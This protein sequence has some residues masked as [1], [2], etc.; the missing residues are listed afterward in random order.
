MDNQFSFCTLNVDG[1]SRDNLLNQ[2]DL[3]NTLS[4]FHVISLNE[5]G[6]NVV[7]LAQEL[8]K[9]YQSFHI[10]STTRNGKGSGVSVLVRHSLAQHTSLWKLEPDVPCIWIKITPE[11]TGLSRD[12]FV[13]SIY[14]PPDG[15]DQYRQ[16]ISHNS[17][18]QLLVQHAA[19]ASS[20][21]HVLI[22]GDFNARVG[23]LND[24]PPLAPWHITPTQRQ[25]IDPVI[26]TAGHLLVEV[27]MA[28]KLALLTG[29]VVGDTPPPISF[30][31]KYRG[32]SR[33]DHVIA[34][35]DLF[36]HITSHSV[37]NKD[38]DSDHYALGTY[39]D[40]IPTAVPNTVVS[41]HP[42]PD[43]YKW[44][45]HLQQAYSTAIMHAHSDGKISDSVDCL[46]TD[47]DAAMEQFVDTI[48]DCARHAGVHPHNPS[49][50]STKPKQYHRPK[51][52]PWF[53]ASCKQALQNLKAAHNNNSHADPEK[54]RQ[55]RKK[56][57][58][59]CR[60]KKRQ[61]KRKV[62]FQQ[63]TNM[64]TNRKQ[65]WK[66]LFPKKS[67]PQ[68][69][70]AD[71]SGCVPHFKAAFNPPQPTT[72]PDQHSEGDV[73]RVDVGNP[74]DN[75]DHALNSEITE[76]EVTT[77]I[78]TLK[79]NKATG[80]DGIS[81]EFLKYAFPKV[82][83][84]NTAS[85]S[86]MPQPTTPTSQPHIANSNPLIAPIT[87]I[88]N[89]ILSSGTTPSA[90][91]HTFI[92]L[93]FKKGD[94]TQWSNYRPIAVT[95]IFSKLYATVLHNRLTNW[96]EANNIR[97]AA[98]TGFRPK[99]GTTHHA[100]VL[101]HLI[102]TH[103]HDKKKLY[104]CFIDLA[105]AYDSVP[106]H[107]LW[108]KLYDLDIK[109]HILHSIIALYKK[110]DISIKYGDGLLDSFEASIG[111]K[112]GC[113]L[114][115]LL[116]GLFIEG[117]EDH[118][119]D[120][121]PD[122][123]PTIGTYTKIKVPNLMFADDTALIGIDHAQLQSL[124]DVAS[125][126]CDENDMTINVGKTEIVIFRKGHRA[127]SNL[128]WTLNNNPIEVVEFF[129]YLGVVFHSWKNANF[130]AH[131]TT[132]CGKIALA[133]MFR[134]LQNLDIGANINLRIHMYLVSVSPV[135]LYGS[136]V[137][138]LYDTD[139]SNPVNSNKSLAESLQITFLKSTLQVRHNTPAWIVY[140]ECGLLPMQ[141]AIIQRQLKFFNAVLQLPDTEYVKAALLESAEL[142]YRNPGN[143]YGKLHKV[144][145]TCSGTPSPF[146]PV[147]GCCV[148]L[149]MQAW[150][151]HYYSRIWGNLHHDPASAPPDGVRLCTY[152]NYFA[153]SIPELD[154]KWE[155][156]TYLQNPNIPH[157]H[158]ISMA[159]FRTGS[160][161]LK[162]ETLRKHKVPR[163]QRTCNL[164]KTQS[165]QDELHVVYDCTQ[166]N[167]HRQ[168]YPR[169]PF[170]NMPSIKDLYNDTNITALVASYTH[171]LMSA[172]NACEPKS[173]NNRRRRRKGNRP[174]QQRRTNQQLE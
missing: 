1:L 141:H 27:C 135:V 67:T 2:D 149:N 97:R 15:S 158:C 22:Q 100:F 164:C 24:L 156:A 37:I 154:Q 55:L 43:S 106:R 113:P 38:L 140:R 73:N 145:Q 123:G 29:R 84:H 72:P 169:I 99:R 153:V 165:V 132:K 91:S 105:K 64:R 51:H 136:E 61:Y 129:K 126:W 90:W 92:T 122:A 9:D 62:A 119:R 81:A 147:D 35:Y 150:R 146:N 60:Q 94:P 174:K 17:R 49:R 173:G 142:S 120:R 137:W 96:C 170:S 124:I 111:V 108:K 66:D 160:H 162:I 32:T 163:E 98:Q 114:S 50:P 20:L 103:R 172:V 13:G 68:N 5:T 28:N 12:L 65:F 34:S 16:N 171:T 71:P 155:M 144:M 110:V 78:N 6:N 14:I 57:H 116:F 131:H 148:S 31:S 167:M 168:K 104:V 161:R 139:L 18:Y 101:N 95:P 88:F 102:E 36:P 87:S 157:Q 82:Q 3:H 117:L 83:V 138:G 58:N 26:N 89:Q 112:Q 48:K 11:G 85:P 75:P 52:K 143:W 118:I 41:T 93:L 47:L 59:T 133:G 45:P 128:I 134:K 121:L 46:D 42:L 30:I 69:P 151:C 74:G 127:P 56:Y 80:L 23:N 152:H 4:A 7:D 79:N 8:F 25:C 86:T 10:P 54:I 166:C 53:D 63:V 21:G 19:V 77:A 76:E 107:R 125:E 115:P 159:Q 40:S 44:K 33:P 70:L 130:A 109:G 39:L